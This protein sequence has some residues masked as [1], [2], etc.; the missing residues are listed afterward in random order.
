MKKEEGFDGWP[1]PVM[2]ELKSIADSLASDM[3]RPGWAHSMLQPDN[4]P[5]S[6]PCTHAASSQLVITHQS[7]MNSYRAEGED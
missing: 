6:V 3:R 7:Y 1:C 4:H 2:Q 5:Y